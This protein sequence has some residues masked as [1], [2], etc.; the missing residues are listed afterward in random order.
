MIAA[1]ALGKDPSRAK[2]IQSLTIQL[3]LRLPHVNR[4]VTALVDYS[5]HDN[6]LSQKLMVK[7]GLQAIPTSTGA[8]IIDGHRI[9]I[10]G[11]HAC[12][13]Q[14]IDMD[15]TKKDIKQEFLTTDSNQYEIILSLP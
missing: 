11:Q 2:Q 3:I 7:E 4:M 13:T 1:V 14:A 12:Y 8:Y 6:F 9:I 5:A 15:G 10:Y